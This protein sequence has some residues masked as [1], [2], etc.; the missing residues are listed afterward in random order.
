MKNISID[1]EARVL[2]K[3]I[4]LHNRTSICNYETISYWGERESGSDVGED[5]VYAN[6]ADTSPCPLQD[7]PFSLYISFTVPYTSKDAILKVTP[8]LRVR[9]FDEYHNKVGCVETGDLAKVTSSRSMQRKGRHIFVLSIMLFCVLITICFMGHQRRRRKEERAA[10]KKQASIMRRF[11]YIQTTRSG[12]VQMTYSP[13]LHGSFSIASDG[14]RRGRPPT[15]L[16]N[17]DD[18]SSASGIAAGLA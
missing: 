6:D 11:H 10:V 3:K 8:D 15:I 7:G 5:D 14:S 13:S 17:H 12:E 18:S 4:Y 2:G 16:E 9:F 1:V